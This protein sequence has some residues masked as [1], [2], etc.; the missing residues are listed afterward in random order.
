MEVL[1]DSGKPS[2]GEGLVRILDSH[3]RDAEVGWQLGWRIGGD[4]TSDD[5]A[6]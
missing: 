6:I 2:T 1:V 5:L 4:D 3:E